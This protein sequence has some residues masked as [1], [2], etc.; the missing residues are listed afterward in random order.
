MGEWSWTSPSSWYVNP[1]SWET[2]TLSNLSCTAMMLC[3]PGF[4]W[5]NKNRDETKYRDGEV[6]LATI[7]SVTPVMAAF[8]L[9]NPWILLGSAPA[10][11]W[12]WWIGS[13][14]PADGDTDPRYYGADL[15]SKHLDWIE[16]QA[17]LVTD[18]L[19][20]G[21]SQTVS[22]V[23]GFRDL[24]EPLWR[25]GLNMVCKPFSLCWDYVQE[26]L[27]TGRRRLGAAS[28]TPTF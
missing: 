24:E 7:G 11:V 13:A 5:W 26:H 3:V 17:R 4:L 22:N 2:S 1:A 27:N 21:K 8:C 28:S 20:S 10:L 6:A 12:F 16:K 25:T 23:R 19:P 14:E 9:G 15:I 18:H